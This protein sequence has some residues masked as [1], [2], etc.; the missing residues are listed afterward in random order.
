MRVSNVRRIRHHHRRD[1]QFPVAPLIRGV[2]AGVARSGEADGGEAGSKDRP[3]DEARQFAVA[4]ATGDGDEVAA[5]GVEE[6]EEE[7]G[8]RLLSVK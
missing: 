6:L 1:S 5:G 8:R 4:P 2:D 7:V 3:F